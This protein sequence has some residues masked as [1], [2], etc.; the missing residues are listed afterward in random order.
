MTEKKQIL[1]IHTG[2]TQKNGTGSCSLVDYLRES[3]GKGYEIVFPEMPD[4][5][6]PAY[7]RWKMKLHHELD[8]LSDEVILIGHSLG[9]SVLLK[10]LSEEKCD[11]KIHGLFIIAAPYWGKSNW[12]ADE[13]T[14]R[15]NFGTTLPGIDHTFLYHCTYDEVVPIDHLAVYSYKLPQAEIRECDSGGHLFS[16]GNPDLITD[17]INIK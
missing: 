8:A 6:N 16:G 3:L 2:G 4:P 12:K 15:E 5:E 9:G 1:F 14:L 11:K 10:Y 17:I 7:R 13:F